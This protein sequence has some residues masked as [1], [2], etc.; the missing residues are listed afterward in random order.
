MKSGTDGA[1]SN[2][3]WAMFFNSRI[4]QAYEC[5]NAA[6]VGVTA[7]ADDVCRLYAGRNKNNRRCGAQINSATHSF[8]QL[9]F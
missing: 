6:T 2:V 7:W 8:S 1:P 3:G 5:C 4:V 9:F